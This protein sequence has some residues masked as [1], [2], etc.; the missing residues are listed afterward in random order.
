MTRSLNVTP[1]TTEQHLIARSDKSVAYVCLCST[2][3]TVEANYWTD[4]KYRTAFLRQQSYLLGIGGAVRPVHLS[5]RP[6]VTN[7]YYSKTNGHRITRLYQC[8]AQVL[9]FKIWVTGR[10][11]S[12]KVAPFDRAY[13]TSSTVGIVWCGKPEWCGY[14]TVKT[15][16][17][18]RHNTDMSRTEG[19]TDEHLAAA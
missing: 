2:F 19:Q 9:F 7:Q 6:S 5:V 15:K 4:T 17:M 13:T 3:C 8:V 1:K 11:R 12:L 18:F 10:S 14:P 16:L